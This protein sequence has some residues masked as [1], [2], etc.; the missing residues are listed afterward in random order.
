[1]RNSVVGICDVNR[2]EP[3]P[4]PLRNATQSVA[5]DSPFEGGSRGMFFG[6]EWHLDVY[7]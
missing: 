6:Q 4:S 7:P 3:E 2:S 1:M 5:R